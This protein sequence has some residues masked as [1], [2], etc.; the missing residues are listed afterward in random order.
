MIYS[1]LLVS[2]LSKNWRTFPPVG[3]IWLQPEV[4]HAMDIPPPHPSSPPP[5]QSQCMYVLCLLPIALYCTVIYWAVLSVCN[6]VYPL[7]FEWKSRPCNWTAAAG[8]DA[9]EI[10]LGIKNRMVISLLAISAPASY[11]RSRN[12]V[13]FFIFLSQLYVCNC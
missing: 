6:L 13:I 7:V 5:L 9:S 4:N 3:D 8:T 1:N 12:S 10:I 2:F 11:L